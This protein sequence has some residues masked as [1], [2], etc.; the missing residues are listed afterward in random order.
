[1][2][3][4]LTRTCVMLEIDRENEWTW[5]WPRCLSSSSEMASCAYTFII[6]LLLNVMLLTGTVISLQ[7]SWNS[8]LTNPI[9]Q[10]LRSCDTVLTKTADPSLLVHALLD[11]SMWLIL[12]WLKLV[13]L[14]RHHSVVDKALEVVDQYQANITNLEHDI[15]LKPK[16]TAV[17][18]C[19][20]VCLL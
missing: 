19:T 8:N 14:N 10:R 20:F 3:F 17:K 4:Y 7:S 1:M 2:L 18:K 16:M 12:F 9:S 5:M 6:S 13:K 15:L 11:L